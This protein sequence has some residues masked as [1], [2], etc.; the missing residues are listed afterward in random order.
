[1]RPHGYDVIRHRWWTL[2]SESLEIMPTGAWRVMATLT[3]GGTEGLVEL[4]FEIDP[5]ADVSSTT[6]RLS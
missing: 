2:R 5:G 1:L 6:K 4:R 3:A